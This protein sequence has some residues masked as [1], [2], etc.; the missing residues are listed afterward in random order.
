MADT[1]TQL[2]GSV[3]QQLRRLLAGEVD[4][5]RVERTPHGI[6]IKTAVEESH[7]AHDGASWE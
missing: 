7:E 6:E 1:Q 5:I 3:I 4:E 2:E